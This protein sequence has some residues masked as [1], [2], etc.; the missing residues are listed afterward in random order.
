MLMRGDV[1]KMIIE[2]NKVL[3]GVFKRLE[4]LENR[5]EGYSSTT[6]PDI[7]KRGPGRPPGSK[8]KEKKAA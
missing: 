2:V 7:A 8:N 3:E 5:S 4:A 1:N 6:V